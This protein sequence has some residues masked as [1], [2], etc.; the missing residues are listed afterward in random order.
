MKIPVS[1][2]SADSAMQ[3]ILGGIL[4]YPDTLAEVARLITVADVRDWNHQKTFQAA[5]DLW[6]AS[7]P[8]DLVA[9]AQELALRQAPFQPSIP[10]YLA[11]LFEQA[12]PEPTVPRHAE[13]V[14]DFAILRRLATAAHAIAERAD[15]PDA[16]CR[17]IVEESER[18][19]Y[20]ISATGTTGEVHTLADILAEVMER[21]DDRKLRGTQGAAI[22]TGLAPLDALSTGMH[23]GSLIILASRPSVGKTAVALAISVGIVRTGKAVFFASLEQSRHELGERLLCAGARISLHALRDSNLDTHD[24]QNLLDASAELSPLPILVDDAS[25][26]SV[27]R[28]AANARRLR[29][30]GMLDAVVIDYLQLVAPEDRKVPRHEQ[31]AAISRRLKCL[32]RDLCVPVIALCQLNREVEGRQ[33][34]KPRLSDLRDSGQ[35][36][37]DGD[38]VILLHR[39]KQSPDMLEFNLAKHRNG[40][41]GEF[42]MLFDR[43]RMRLEPTVRTPFDSR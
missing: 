19:V 9:M 1:W 8:F 13:S 24:V 35:I 30:R 17:Q 43:A 21:L 10:V 22:Q 41:T 6:A 16:P 34:G 14:R 33:D 26:Q 42:T 5:L 7:R 12:A 31:V 2:E 3:A 27:Q 18:S 32:A 28:I 38:L 11:D 15:N 40:P 20:A 29:S 4:R 23:P 36:E 25:T 37:Q 39:D